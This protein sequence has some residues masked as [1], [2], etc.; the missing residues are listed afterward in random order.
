MEKNSLA[1]CV[2]GENIFLRDYSKFDTNEDWD[3]IEEKFNYNEYQKAILNLNK[4]NICSLKG[5]D[6]KVQMKLEGNNLIL[7]LEK[8][9]KL[10]Q[11]IFADKRILA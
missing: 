1:F 8:P 9:N 2:E 5:D 10:Y 7:S 11:F 6:C 3:V 4:D